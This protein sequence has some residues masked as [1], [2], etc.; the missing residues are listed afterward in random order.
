MDKR[1]GEKSITAT[2]GDMFEELKSQANY[3]FDPSLW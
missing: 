2:V 1:A 3:F